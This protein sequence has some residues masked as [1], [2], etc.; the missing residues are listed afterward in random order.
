MPNITFY[1][2]GDPASEFQAPLEKGVITVGRVEGNDIVLPTGEISRRHVR[3]GLKDG[4]VFVEDMGSSNGTFVNAQK[5]GGQ[6]LLGPNDVARIGPWEFKLAVAGAA[7]GQAPAP[8]VADGLMATKAGKAQGVAA[9]KPT[10]PHAA[11]AARPGFVL[12]IRDKRTR[13]ETEQPLPEGETILG[14]VA[15]ANVVLPSDGVSRRHLSLTRT[16][17]LVVMR[18]LGS[19]NGTFVNGHRIPECSLGPQDVVEVGDYEILAGPERG[20][21]AAV[22]ASAVVEKARSAGAAAVALGDASSVRA[23]ARKPGSRTFL[24]KEGEQSREILSP[25]ITVGRMKENDIVLLT[26]LASRHHASLSAAGDKLKLV[27]PGSSNGTYVNDKLVSECMIGDGAEIIIGDFVLQIGITAEAYVVEVKS[28]SERRADPLDSATDPLDQGIRVES[29]RLSNKDLRNVPVLDALDPELLNK[30]VPLSQ[31]GAVPPGQPVYFPGRISDKLY[32]VISGRV[33]EVHTS[34]KGQKRVLTSYGPGDFFGDSTVTSGGA[35]NVACVTAQQ[36]VLLGVPRDEI[37]KYQKRCKPFAKILDERYREKALE[38][39]LKEIG[40]FRSVDAAAIKDLMQKAKLHSFSKNDVIIKEGDEGDSFYLVRSGYCKIHKAKKAEQQKKK[41]KED[42]ASFGH[43]LADGTSAEGEQILAYVR[44]GTYFGEQAIMTGQPRAASVTAMTE[45][46]LVQIMKEDFQPLLDRF[47]EIGVEIR[48]TLEVRQLKAIEASESTFYGRMMDFVVEQGVISTS[49]ILVVDLHKCIRCDDCIRACTAHHGQSRFTM[50]G[51]RFDNLLIV[52]S[53]RN[54]QNPECL[55]GCPTGNITRDLNGE[56]HFADKCIGCSNCARR[57][58]YGDIIMV[59]SKDHAYK[60]QKN[61]P[62]GEVSEKRP[63]KI[64]TKC[65]LCR[66]YE[67]QACV[68]SCPTG[69]AMRV[70]P[71]SFFKRVASS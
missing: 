34:E 70:D 32:V 53:C 51:V 12:L 42:F 63:Q 8:A 30:L 61:A 18:D 48:K 6:V 5:I 62:L 36:T 71:A 68:V 44:A 64:A 41:G 65:D 55:I 45:V 11:P 43:K 13:Q 66:E 54:C 28:I 2:P 1:I 4:R 16:G 57:C 17:D 31:V 20:A 29:V 50:K 7:R 52:S 37:T 69:A 60:E 3:I 58:P 27:D 15:P 26:D 38:S 39:H 23:R 10:A 33:D 40:L 24:I 67:Y 59:E 49:N 47:P 35:G 25:A 9:A 19:S 21:P 56:I 46:E 14:R 22:V